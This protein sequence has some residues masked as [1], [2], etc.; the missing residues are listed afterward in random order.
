MV[1]TPV[2]SPFVAVST[3]VSRGVP[4][5]TGR[6]VLTGG[7]LARMTSV[8]SDIWVARSSRLIA[9]TASRIVL[10]TSAAVSV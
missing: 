8:G 2:Q 5:A 3:W 1:A 7:C 6:T 9:V 4:V 10:P